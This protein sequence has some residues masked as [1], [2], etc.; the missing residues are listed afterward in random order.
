MSFASSAWAGRSARQASGIAGRLD[1]LYPNPSDDVNH[2]L[3]QLLVYL[4]SPSVVPKSLALLDKGQTQE[5]QLYYMFNLRNV[6]AAGRRNSANGTSM[7]STSP[8]RNTAAGQASSCSGTT[9]AAM[10][11]P[12]SANDEKVALGDKLKPPME[13][14]FA[15]GATP[16]TQYKFVRELEDG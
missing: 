13:L 5:E 6:R 12:R 11:S 3:C 14:G 8:S 9:S 15:S 16:A 4:E 1:A 10:R 2:E 7:H